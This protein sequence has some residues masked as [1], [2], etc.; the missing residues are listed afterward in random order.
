MK[1]LITG[2]AGFIG[3]HLSEYLLRAGATVTV[4]DDLSTGRLDNLQ[5]VEARPGFRFIQDTVMNRELMNDLV[6]RHDV[7]YHLAAAV[8]VQR[9][10]QNPLQSLYTNIHATEIVLEAAVRR[11]TRVLLASTSEVYGKNDKAALSEDDDSIIGSTQITRW[12]YANSKA[13]DE[14]LALAYHREHNLP[15]VIVRFFNTVGPR[16]TGRYGMVVPRFVRQ[17]IAGEPLTIHGDG[18]QTRCFTDVRDSVRA[19]YELSRLAEASGE[20]FNIGN[21]RE[22]SIRGLAELVVKLTGSRSELRLV[23]YSDVYPEGFEDMRRRVP[24]PTKL[25]SFL[26]WAPCLPLEE[27]LQRI[28]EAMRPAAAADVAAPIAFPSLVP[29][30]GPAAAA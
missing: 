30:I 29:A 13:T 15:V 4:V 7:V 21:P 27:N 23:P 11:R 24:D 28:I 8:G 6:P 17:A 16:Q 1:A 5:A 19:V 9:I 26:G 3:S 10:L 25:R 18:E 14:F 22:I 2:G 12:L 20:V